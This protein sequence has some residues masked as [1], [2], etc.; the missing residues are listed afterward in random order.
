MQVCIQAKP[1]G[2][3]HLLAVPGEHEQN[4]LDATL[5]K[6]GEPRTRPTLSRTQNAEP[7]RTQDQACAEWNAECRTQN[8]ATE[9]NSTPV[10]HC[11]YS[12]FLRTMNEP[13]LQ[14]VAS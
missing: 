7:K 1:A 8:H 3:P 5:R 2:Q 9:L 11:F 6:S 10:S 14:P 12:D 13:D 4:S